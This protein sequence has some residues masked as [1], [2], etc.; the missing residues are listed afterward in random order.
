MKIRLLIITLFITFFSIAQ[1]GTVTGVLTDKDMNNEPLPFANALIKGTS[2]GTTTDEKGFYSLSVEPGNYILQLSFLGYQTVEV[3]I[4]VK[5]G[6]TVTVNKALT[7]GEGVM[8]QDVVVVTSRRKNT[9]AAV[10]IEIKEAKQVVSAISAEQMSKGTDSNAADAIQRV[11]GVTIV[12]GKFVMIRGLSERYNNVLINNAVAPSTEV[13]KRTFAF[14]LIPT[15]AMDKMVIIKTGSADKPGDFSGGI[16]NITTSENITE[17]NTFNVGFG[18]RMDTSFD[19]YYQSE[20]S[21]TDFLGFDYEFRTLP[22]TF[23]SAN[24]INTY[25]EV[26]VT[27]SNTKLQNNF[28]PNKSTA[29]LDNNFGFAFGRSKKFANGMNLQSVNMFGYSNTYLTYQRQFTR[30]TTL[31]EGETRPPQWLNY[32]DDYNQNEARVTVLSNWIFKLDNDNTIKFKNLFNQIGENETIIRNGNNYLQR[33]EDLFRNY[34]LGYTSRSIYTGQ[35]E[36]I[37]QLNSTNAI[38]WV[39]GYNYM[40]QSE[41]D[42]RRFRTIKD[43]EDPN[44]VYEMIDP[45]STNLFDTG[46]Y[47]G[48]L[49][50]YSV[51]NGA[52]YTHNIERIKNDEELNPIK[53]KT[54]YYLDYR[55]RAFDSRYVSYFLPDYGIDRITEL[56]QLPLTDIF[57]PENVNT[58]DGWILKEGTRSIDS[59][60]ADNFLAAGYIYGE[61]PLNKFDISAGVRVE[62]NILSLQSNTD[63][64]PIDIE[65]P[66][67]SILPSLNVGYNISERALVRFAYSRTVNRP[68]FREI[69]PFLFYDYENEAAKVGNAELKT[70]E[71]DNIDLRYEFYPNKGETMSLGAFYKRF[72]NPIENV[73]QITTEQPQFNYANAD[74]AYNYGVELEIRKSFKELTNNLYLGRLS[75]NIN[76]SYIFSEVDLGGDVTSQ[77]QVRALQGQSP[78]IVNVAL[79]Y[80]D[81]TGFSANVIYNRFGDRIF[82]VGDINFPTIYELSRNSLDLTFSKTFKKTTIKLGI[83]DLL[84]AKYQFYEDSNRDEKISKD[85]DNATSVFKK[86]TLFSLNLTHNF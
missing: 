65:N 59:Y 64:G 71:I 73:T 81:E 27:A 40:Y 82:S 76:A 33:G 32:L 80:T 52:N 74:S 75:A 42:L 16:V 35:L 6:Q 13:D 20:G 1:K 56:K 14:D 68:E 11:P 41:P 66:V 34:L 79:G 45:A 4:T 5:A 39:A 9:E 28:N 85:I 72:D 8:L 61:F 38:D 62:H 18:Y 30:Y 48:T 2:I 60:D 54:G 50:E 58:T 43:V 55:K 10:M 86:G 26:G 17:F 77:A 63:L 25:P 70:A 21:K 44:S 3:P 37:H 67:T 22:S 53:L 31:N 47:F 46:R 83:Q 57:S 24:L 23:P 36:G 84:N 15:K 19:T 78:Y 29:L 51:N 49:S 69:A 12:D 7:S